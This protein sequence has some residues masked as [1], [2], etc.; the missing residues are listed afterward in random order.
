[1]ISVTRKAHFSAA[2]RL[3]NPAWSAEHNE[4]VFGKCN[5]PAYHGH[6]YVVEVTVSGP[7]DPETG[8]VIDLKV[9]KDLID[10]HV[11]EPLDH[12]NLNTD[13]PFLHGIIPTAENIAVAIWNQLVSRLPQGT[14]EE[15]VLHETEHNRV[16]VN[17]AH[18][19]DL[20]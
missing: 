17:R 12:K 10:A 4:A 15:I 16:K 14:L 5:N 18:V 1:M 7:I 2:H 8:Y 13:V 6:N 3:T 20:S 19:T 11:I 9:L